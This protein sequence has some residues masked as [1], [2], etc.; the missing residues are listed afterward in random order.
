MVGKWPDLQPFPDQQKV[1]GAPFISR[2]SRLD[3]AAFFSRP[4]ANG[5]GAAFPRPKAMNEAPSFS[6]LQVLGMVVVSPL[7]RQVRGRRQSTNGPTTKRH[8]WLHADLPPTIFR[9]IVWVL[10]IPYTGPT[11]IPYTL[12][13]IWFAG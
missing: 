2:P 6:H 4:S 12:A 3:G 13:D 8:L 9:L 7:C 10:P 11:K 5:Q 1:G